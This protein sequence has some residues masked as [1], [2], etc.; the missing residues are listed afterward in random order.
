MWKGDLRQVNA[1]MLHNHNQKIP[2]CLSDLKNEKILVMQN[3][4]FE[5]WQVLHDYSLL[6]PK[7]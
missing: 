1:R 3:V 7:Q 4:H 5:F 6:H 2:I